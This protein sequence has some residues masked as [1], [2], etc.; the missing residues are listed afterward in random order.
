MAD[1]ETKGKD[2]IPI[3]TDQRRVNQKDPSQMVIE[4]MS[5]ETT[6]GNKG[7]LDVDKRVTSKGTA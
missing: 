6:E 3:G 2:E 1:G 4:V 7:A 5:P